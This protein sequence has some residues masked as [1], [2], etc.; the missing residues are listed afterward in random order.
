[1]S[2]DNINIEL[3]DEIIDV[4][5]SG[6]NGVDGVTGPTGPTGPA[7]GPTGPTGVDGATGPT[8]ADGATG[9][10]GA[11]GATGPTGAGTTGAT[12]PTGVAGVDGATGPTGI[13]G[14][15]GTTGATGP[16]GVA[17]VDG[18]TGPTGITG[19]TGP[20]TAIQ[21]TKTLYVDSNR[22]DSYVEDGSIATPFKTITDANTTA[23]AGC[24][25]HVFPGTYTDNITTK[26]GVIYYAN[27]GDYNTSQVIMTG[28]FGIEASD[29]SIVGFDFQ[30]PISHAIQV[31]SVNIDNLH[32]LKNRIYNAGNDPILFNS[33]PAV[34]HTNIY[35]NDN[36]IEKVDGTSDSGIWF[37]HVTGGEIKNNI[38]LDIGYNG[39]I[40]DGIKD[41][42]I[43]GNDIRT[44][45]QSGIQIASSTGANTIVEHNYFYGNNTSLSS[46]K[47]GMAIY[48]SADDLKIRYNIFDSNYNGF[49]VRNKAGVAS[50]DIFINYNEFINS[51]N[52]G[53]MNLAQS[54]GDLN[55]KW[56]WF[57]DSSGCNDDAGVINGTG[58]AITT[59][60]VA[61]PLK[62]Y[63]NTATDI[64][65]DSLVT[66][67][68]VKDALN[69]LLATG[70][71]TGPTGATGPTG[72]AG[73]GSDWADISNKPSSNVADIDDAVDKKHT[74]NTDTK[75]DEGG[76]NEK[77][78]EELVISSLDGDWKKVTEIQYNTVT[79][80]LKFKYEE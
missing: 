40:A 76:V 51:T 4:A 59:N 50:A 25:I 46:D 7:G 6:N 21:A 61:E 55:G 78:V 10:T 74:Q 31:L 66:G 49:T 42:V 80:K 15:A 16:T 44:C 22:T 47:G 33:V 41:I 73:S 19:P 28:T 2:N 60:V 56:N 35:I 70:A 18:A 23:T 65:N 17:G 43:S 9:P 72:V 79:Q 14:D 68:T 39:I 58:D 54:G 77:S 27:G 34:A 69:S 52:Y 37:Y 24:L 38:I 26:Q 62:T 3:T 53:I 71:I 12:G 75:L 1:M 11:D 32:I 67:P 57:G 5:I 20:G 64:R 48:P 8:G 30:S 29:V 45:G 13:T 36:R 63:G